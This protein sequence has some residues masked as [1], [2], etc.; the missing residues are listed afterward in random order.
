MS[1]PESISQAKP[2]SQAKPVFEAEKVTKRYRGVPVVEEVSL[3]LAPGETLCLFGPN[4]AGKTTLLRIAA[5][6]ARPSSGRLRYRGI[7]SQ[8]AVPAAR[9]WIGFASHQSLLYPEL[10]VAENLRFHARLHRKSVD[11]GALLDRHGLRV[12]ADAPACHLSRGTAQRAT[13]ARALL[14]DP[15]LLLLDE[16]FA[17]LDGAAGDR[18]LRLLLGARERGAAVLAATHDVERGLR[19]ADRSLVLHRGRLLLDD[20]GAG[21]EAIRKAYDDAASGRAPAR[22]P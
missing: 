12:V 8:R 16:P 6:L 9:G 21:A 5:T 19:I 3:A 22:R 10:T 13:L 11:L 4:G 7:E 15:D 2:T 14:H 17:G 18:L 1:T 20:P